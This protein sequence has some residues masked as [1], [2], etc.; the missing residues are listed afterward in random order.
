LTGVLVALIFYNFLLYFASSRK[1]N[2][3]YSMYLASGAIWIALSYGLFANAFDLYGSDI[4]RLHI[5]L[6]TMPVFLILFMMAIFE[7]RENYPTEHRFLQFMLALLVLDF[8]YALFDIQA[9]LKPASTLAAM[10]MLITISVS[11]SLF[12]KGNPLA[13][14]SSLAIPSFLFSTPSRYFFI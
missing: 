4:F 13:R 6:I 9:A 1:E 14:F 12:I 8:G 3:Y 2:I 5:T 7:T 10:M 11:I